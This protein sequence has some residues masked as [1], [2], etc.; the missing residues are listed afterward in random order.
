MWDP[1][2]WFLCQG[3]WSP[4]AGLYKNSAAQPGSTAAPE[5]QA[6]A[7]LAPVFAVRRSLPVCSVTPGGTQQLLTRCTH[8]VSQ[9]SEAGDKSACVSV[10]RGRGVKGDTLIWVHEC[11][12]YAGDR[13]HSVIALLPQTSPLKRCFCPVS[14]TLIPAAACLT[15]AFA[16]VGLL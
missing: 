13:Q 11:N 6:A 15:G 4:L 10:R 7:N 16:R 1:I 14:P 3:R 9:W 2:K 8:R 12:A 5:T